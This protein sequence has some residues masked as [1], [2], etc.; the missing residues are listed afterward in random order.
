[1]IPQPT[2]A[3]GDVGIRHTLVF[4]RK[5]KAVARPVRDVADVAQALGG[6]LATQVGELGDKV[7]VDL[8]APRRL[9]QRRQD[10]GHDLQRQV[11]GPAWPEGLG[12][13]V[14]EGAG[15]AEGLRQARPGAGALHGVTAGRDIRRCSRVAQRA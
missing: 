12:A 3:G 14:E 8:R 13:V 1:M 6:L 9:R 2:E 11:P 5:N 15:G 10:G 7:R 4:A